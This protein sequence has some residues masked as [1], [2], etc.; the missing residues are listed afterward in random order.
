VTLDELRKDLELLTPRRIADAA[1]AI[2]I[3]DGQT[4]PVKGCGSIRVAR[5]GKVGIVYITSKDAGVSSPPLSGNYGIKVWI[6]PDD[7]VFEAWWDPFKVT[8]FRPGD[9]EREILRSPA[10]PPDNGAGS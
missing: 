9:W 4:V 10:H 5:L 2:A 8:K 7:E 3:R 1:E 6:E